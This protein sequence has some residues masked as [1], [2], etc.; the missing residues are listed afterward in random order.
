MSKIQFIERDGRREFAVLPMEWF[1]IVAEKLE[2]L[3]EE[4][5]Y[6]QARANDDGFRVPASVARAILEGGHPVRVWREHRGL[7]QEALAEKAGIS[8]AFLCQIETGKRAGTI[9]TLKLLATALG[10]RLDDIH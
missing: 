1:E 5:L 9:K 2:S 10:L 8:K 6:D 3:E 4:A 7:T